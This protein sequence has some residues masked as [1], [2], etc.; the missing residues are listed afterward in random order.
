MLVALLSV[1]AYA[2]TDGEAEKRSATEWDDVEVYEQNRLY[3]RVN[4]IPYDDENDI[5][6][7]NYFQSSSYI[8]LDEGWVVDYTNDFADRVSEIEKRD[9][10]PKDWQS[11]VFPDVRWSLGGRVFECRRLAKVA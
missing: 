2:Q 1:A 5:E 4:V 11:L 6:K 7:W 10:S 3:P 8:L 9:F